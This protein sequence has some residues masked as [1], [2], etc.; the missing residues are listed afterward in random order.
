MA[1]PGTCVHFFPLTDPL[2]PPVCIRCGFVAAPVPI[3]IPEPAPMPVERGDDVSQVAQ[4]KPGSRI[5]NWLKER[6]VAE[7]VKQGASA[8]QAQAAFEEAVGASDRPFL[9]WLANGGFEKL[10]EIVMTIIKML[11]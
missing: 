9:D 6:I 3:P 8:E 2:A 11:A 1:V 4:W 7:A 5:R 10:L